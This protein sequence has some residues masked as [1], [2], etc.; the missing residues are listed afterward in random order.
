MH[1]LRTSTTSIRKRKSLKSAFSTRSHQTVFSE[2]KPQKDSGIF[3]KNRSMADVDELN[4]DLNISTNHSSHREIGG[5]SYS[6]K[7]WAKKVNNWISNDT[8][9]K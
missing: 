5:K 1:N 6:I 8:S 9:F 7:T 3:G 4:F 2:D